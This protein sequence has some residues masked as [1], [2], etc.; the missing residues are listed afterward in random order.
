MSLLDVKGLKAGYG[1][2]TI[3]QGID[4][5]IPE[6][7]FIGIL[8][9]NGM[10]KSTLMKTIAGQIRPSAG[11]IAFAGTDLGNAAPHRRAAIGL[12]Y[13]PQGREIFPNLSVE[14][15]LRMGL[16]RLSEKQAAQ[17]S[18]EAV[19]EEFP[20]LKP[21]LSRRGG[22]LSGGEQQI[23]AIARSLV[24]HPRLLMLDEPTEGIQPSIV[25]EIIAVLHEL[26]RKRRL[27]LLLVEQKL[28]FIAALAD[29][30]LVLQRGVITG[31]LAPQQLDD[32]SVVREFVGF[33]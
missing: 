14:E 28:D 31:R 27:T 23:L 25:E 29:E 21:L 4:L 3:L 12:G 22:I 24:G 19:L 9:H 17:D 15:N 2:V 10:G 7:A 16:M 8:G 6:G 13:V 33:G 26:R 11:T 18:F 30:V 32:P 20:R 5:T 1:R